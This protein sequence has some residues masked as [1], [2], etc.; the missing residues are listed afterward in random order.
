MTV[1]EKPEHMHITF[2]NIS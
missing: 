2:T 1:H